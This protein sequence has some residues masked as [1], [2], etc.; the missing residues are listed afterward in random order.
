[1]GL[2]RQHQDDLVR[3]RKRALEVVTADNV[4][5]RLTLA[6]QNRYTID[7]E[8]DI[9]TS[10]DWIDFVLYNP[11]VRASATWAD[12]KEAT[13]TA[14]N[15]LVA[16]DAGSVDHNT[17]GKPLRDGALEATKRMAGAVERLVD[18]LC[19]D[20]PT[21]ASKG[22]EIRGAFDDHVRDRINIQ[23]AL[24]DNAADARME[25][26]CRDV[27]STTASTS[28]SATRSVK[29]RPSSPGQVLCGEF[30]RG[31]ID[32]AKQGGSARLIEPRTSPE[33]RQAVE[34]Y[35]TRVREM[36][37]RATEN[38]WASDV[39]DFEIPSA[40]LG[41]IH[42]EAV[43]Q[44]RVRGNVD[45]DTVFDTV[46]QRQTA[47]DPPASGSVEDVFLGLQLYCSLGEEIENSGFACPR[48]A[49]QQ[50]ARI[51]VRLMDDKTITPK[52]IKAT[53]MLQVLPSVYFAATACEARRRTATGASPPITNSDKSDEISLAIDQLASARVQVVTTTA[54]ILGMDERQRLAV[55]RNEIMH[56]LDA[57]DRETISAIQE[58]GGGQFG[59]TELD[60]YRTAM[61]RLIGDGDEYDDQMIDAYCQAGLDRPYGSTMSRSLEDAV[62]EHARSEG[63]AMPSARDAE[64]SFLSSASTTVY[65]ATNKRAAAAYTDYQLR[66][67][68]ALSTRVRES[69]GLSYGAMM[70]RVGDL[71]VTEET[72]TA[73][74]TTTAG[75]GDGLT[76]TTEGT[77]GL[78]LGSDVVPSDA[79]AGII[80][81]EELQLADDLRVI[82][83]VYEEVHG[84]SA[85]V[86][87]A[88]AYVQWYDAHR[89]DGA[90]GIAAVMRRQYEEIVGAESPGGDGE[91][92]ATDGALMTATRDLGNVA[93]QLAASLKA[94]NVALSEYDLAT[95]LHEAARDGRGNPDAVDKLAQQRL[96]DIATDVRTK[97]GEYRAAMAT[98]PGDLPPSVTGV[99]ATIK[100]IVDDNVIPDDA[101][102]LRA[103]STTLRQV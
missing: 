78:V 102:F 10:G 61:I 8:S 71:M 88:Q 40:I 15:A 72:T 93:P 28:N 100:R 77:P 46:T 24:R 42:A 68:E 16:L 52:H 39:P 41:E 57:K 99:D 84:V 75:G 59:E 81:V 62:R 21:C 7:K 34:V 23:R 56:Q 9:P 60:A 82:S 97:L 35:E 18:D 76:V 70:S 96:H 73:A 87:D 31:A 36:D 3:E 79:P 26:T 22:D 38:G 85:S 27:A 43:A 19:T 33:V 20:I 37:T 2:W 94:L 74:E 14:I 13:N 51:G 1:M 90:D 91:K 58:A 63:L 4:A 5:D 30:T 65:G 83:T 17:E 55:A 11:D 92:V 103:L 101:R 53:Q 29:M 86:Q 48:D 6:L 69:M 25:G 98:A 32:I 47:K 67:A 80:S 45:L 66:L 49:P 54:D 50:V 44:Q 64:Q 89:A 95:A 12:A